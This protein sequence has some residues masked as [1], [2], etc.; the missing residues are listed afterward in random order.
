MFLSYLSL[1]AHPSAL[2]KNLAA[3]AMASI[4]TGEPH[5]VT[6]KDTDPFVA[7]NTMGSAAQQQLDQCRFFYD[8]AISFPVVAMIWAPYNIDGMATNLYHQS[9]RGDDII[10]P[11]L[12]ANIDVCWAAGHPRAMLHWALT[13]MHARDIIA[14]YP[15]P[16]R[17]DLSNTSKLVWWAQRINLRVYGAR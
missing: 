5:I 14:S 17:T 1:P 4:T 11:S 16:A 9:F 3:E 15:G 7:I 8:T 6:T 10:F 13:I 12:A 2:Y